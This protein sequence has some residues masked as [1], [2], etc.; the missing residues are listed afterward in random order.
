MN[1]DSGMVLANGLI[2]FKSMP[3]R[4]RRSN[5]PITGPSPVKVRL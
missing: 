3:L 4:N 1:T 5:V 2:A